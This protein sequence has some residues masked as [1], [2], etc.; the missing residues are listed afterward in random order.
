ME[1]FAFPGESYSVSNIEDYFQYI[2]KKHETVTDNPQIKICVNI[3]S[4]LKLK[5]GIISNF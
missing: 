3:E 4:Y 5:Q 1:K 2:I